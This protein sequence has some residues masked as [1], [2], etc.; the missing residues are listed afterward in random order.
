MINDPEFIGVIL[1]ARA[2]ARLFPLTTDAVPGQTASYKH[3]LPLAG[4]PV[5]CR[6]L[7]SVQV[8]GL[9]RVVLAVAQHDN[10][11]LAALQ[12]YY[13]EANRTLTLETVATT[14]STTFTRIIIG[15]SKLPTT[16]P[17]QHARSNSAVTMTTNTNT[18]NNTNT[19]DEPTQTKSFQ[20]DM[21][22][23]SPECIGSADALRYLSMMQ[24]HMSTPDD[25]H[26]PK[27]TWTWLLPRKS[28]V[29]LLPGDLV[30]Q[31]KGLLGVLADAHRR[32]V[33]LNT[34][35]SVS[36]G[37]VTMLL[38]D[39]GENDEST[40]LPLKELAKHKKGSLAREEEDVEYL[41]T[42]SL[43]PN[44]Y[45]V[46]ANISTKPTLLP[47]ERVLLK[48]CKMDLDDQA[49]E[50]GATPKLTILKSLLHHTSSLRLRSDLEDVHLYIFSPWVL[51]LIQ[52]RTHLSSI[53]KEILPLLTIR[54]FKPHGMQGTFGKSFQKSLS[55]GTTTITGT[56]NPPE[57]Q[58]KEE[59]L[60]RA[61]AWAWQQRNQHSKSL[62]LLTDDSDQ[63]S[64]TDNVVNDDHHDDGPLLM[65]AN[66]H[67]TTTPPGIHP[68]DWTSYPTIPY[69]VAA[70]VVPRGS[71]LIMRTFTVN[72][73]SYA[74]REF[75]AHAIHPKPYIFDTNY[76]AASQ[77]ALSAALESS[78]LTVGQLLPKFQSLVMTNQIGEQV[79]MKSSVIG[80]NCIIG[81]RSRL[82]NCVLMD[83]VTI[84]EN[85]VLQNSVLAEGV[86]VGE[87]CNF[88]EVQVGAGATIAP[89][90]KIK[91]ESIVGGHAP[92]EMM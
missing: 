71:R 92:S 12:T 47:L 4:Y 70:V 69:H 79:T 49:K 26:I 52:C 9:S 75:V 19:M 38:S 46:P 39:V 87:N 78:F 73:Y 60:C 35:R 20:I 74:C 6:L 43:D 55:T 22:H 50:T 85:C 64:D 56:N 53:Q 21:V 59:S 23:L 77:A 3:L 81:R 27:T 44:L 40:N 30:L 63:D 72:H 18:N 36:I 54:Q 66:E 16:A 83:R 7:H 48:R 37:S 65:D 84:G 61:L 45:L 51:H 89:S 24:Q 88:N 91:G 11:T 33:C 10:D 1:A 32:N 17:P 82:N 90:T 68:K 25:I 14:T 2:G 29:I 28:N 80:R 41:A 76:Y 34:M 31:G 58:L 62:D 86:V 57:M 8:G 5:I 13:N 42:S 67:T 15:P